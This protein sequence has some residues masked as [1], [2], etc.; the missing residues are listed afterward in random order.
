MLYA[1]IGCAVTLV[2]IFA[3]PVNMGKTSQYV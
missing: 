1:Y 3:V 2:A